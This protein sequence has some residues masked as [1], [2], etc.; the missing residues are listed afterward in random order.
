MPADYAATWPLGEKGG[1]MPE[2]WLITGSHGHLGRSLVEASELLGHEAIHGGRSGWCP[3][4]I[5]RIYDLAAYGNKIDQTRADEIYQAN[6]LRAIAL[7]GN[8]ESI[9]Y[10]SCVLTS[11]SSVLLDHQTHY[12]LSKKAM[13]KMA[14]KWAQDNGKPIVIVRPSTIIGVGESNDHLI[15]KL[16]DSCLHGTEMPFVTEPTHDYLDVRDFIDGV[17]HLASMANKIK[18]WVVNISSGT[19]LSNEEVLAK[20]EKLTSKKA[21][22]KESGRLRPYDSVNWVVNNSAIL[23]LGWKPRYNLEDSIKGMVEVYGKDN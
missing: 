10:K 16:I 8:A 5:D 3:A 7:L 18:G 12:S 2:R 17:I 9:E 23:K 13:E 6:L 22:I 1:K 21:N 19:S 14:T 4:G 11:S 20:V 15:P